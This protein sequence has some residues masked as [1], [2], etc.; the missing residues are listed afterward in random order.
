MT[1]KINRPKRSTGI[2]TGIGTIVPLNT[3]TGIVPLNTG[4]EAVNIPTEAPEPIDPRRGT[5]VGNDADA[6][7]ISNKDAKK[8]GGEMQ[9]LEATETN[10]YQQNTS[11]VRPSL[12]PRD[13][14]LNKEQS[15]SMTRPRKLLIQSQT[16]NGD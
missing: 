10:L 4:T 8:S 3:S 11:L 7:T 9:M 6:T 5:I 13:L 16:T 15:T 14:K 2:G 12:R 1:A